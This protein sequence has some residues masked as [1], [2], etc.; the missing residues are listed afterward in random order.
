[1]N[2][3]GFLWR[4]AKW[5]TS[6]LGELCCDILLGRSLLE[7]LPEARTTLDVVL[8]Q[9]TKADVD[10]ICRLYSSD[11]WL[12]LGDA[13]RP[14][15]SDDG[16]RERYLDR[17]NRGELC[18]IATVA[19]VV[20]HLNWLCSNWGDALPEHP[21]R[22]APGEIFTTDGLTI[23]AF[24]GK[25]LHAYVLRAMLEHARSLGRIHAFTLG[26]IDRQGSYK[27]LFQL[28]WRECGRVVYLV[29]RGKSRAWFLARRGNLDPL[30][31]KQ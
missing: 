20:A 11:P 3:A 26:R 4:G 18:F 24:R 6:P 22:L 30:F 17:L 1:M 13:D 19:G 28:G 23:E 14:A 5:A 2:A 21:I 7:P 31:R 8:R 16:A 27:G 15:G 12:Y 25:G 9:A 29:P 10:E